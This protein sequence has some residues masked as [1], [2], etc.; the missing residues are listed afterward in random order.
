MSTNNHTRVA[1]VRHAE[2]FVALS[3]VLDQTQFFSLLDQHWQ[4]SGKSKADYVVAVKPNIMTGYSLDDPSTI[5]DRELVEKLVDEIVHRGYSNVVV[6]ESQNIYSNWFRNREVRSVAAFH[7][8]TE[9]NYRIV[10]LTEE[11]VAH[12]YGG[13]LGQHWV[14]PTWRDADFRISFAKNKTHMF[15]VF[16]LTLKNIF[17]CFPLVDKYK[18]YHVKLEYDWTT[19]E[20][21]KAFPCH[22]GLVDAIWSADGLLGVKSDYTPKHTQTIIGGENLVAVAW[23]GAKKMGLDPFESRIFKLAAATFGLPE[24]E[25]I[26]DQSVYKNWVNI[27]QVLDELID[28]GEENYGYLDWISSILS[29]MDPTFP[30]KPG[31]WFTRLMRGLMK[32]VV[33]YIARREG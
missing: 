23:V 6:V 13:R 16:T 15:N 20:L 8:Y 14:G 28:A 31:H 4:S 30:P 17:G 32:W 25:W 19:V 27:P 5:T 22:F 1:V 12:D 2:K 7:G 33:R 3:Q 21:L 26:G 29:N 24:V 11:M 10:D 18:E 9:R